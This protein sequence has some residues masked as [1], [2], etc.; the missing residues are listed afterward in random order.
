MREEIEHEKAGKKSKVQINSIF[1]FFLCLVS[2]HLVLIPLNPDPRYSD[3]HV[4]GNDVSM[5]TRATHLLIGKMSVERV[6]WS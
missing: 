1:M 3:T 4:C 5:T 6:V 2:A